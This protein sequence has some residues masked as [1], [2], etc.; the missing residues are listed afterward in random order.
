MRVALA[1]LEPEQ[2]VQA[3]CVWLLAVW[4][5]LRVH[6]LSQQLLSRAQLHEAAVHAVAEEHA[7]DAIDREVGVVMRPSARG[8]RAADRPRRAPQPNAP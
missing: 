3:V 4:R 1:E 5:R 6:Q 8:R 2:E 7:R